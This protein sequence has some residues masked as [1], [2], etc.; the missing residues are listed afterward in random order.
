MTAPDESRDEPGFELKRFIPV[1]KSVSEQAQ[2]FLG[3]G[4]SIGDASGQQPDRNDID[5]WRAVIKA[6]DEMMVAFTEMV[7]AVPASTVDT[8]L[9]GDVQVFVLTPE[10]VPDDDPDQP[11]Y[12]DIHGGA[13]IMG[14]GDACRA[15]AT[16]VAAMTRMRTWSV[17]YRMAPDHPSPAALDDCI[18]VYRR[19]LEIKAPER[20]VVGGGSAGGNLA[21]AL[22]LRARD[23]GLPFPGALVLLTPEADLTALRRFHPAVPAHAHPGRDARSLPLQ[24]GAPAPED[25]NCRRRSGAPRVR[26]D[27]PRRILRRARRRRDRRR[28]PTVPRVTSRAMRSSS[29]VEIRC[30]R[31][32]APRASPERRNRRSCH[33]PRCRSLRSG[34]TPR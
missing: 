21:A 34:T 11:I 17:D 19:L 5:G 20:I 16:K 27:A 12:F 10:G 18:A 15:L 28:D 31:R 13:L 7:P 22:M 8:I 30:V 6:S 3:M 32:R 24:R 23:E 29:V 33:R 2:A 4:L 25:A 26:G 9:V 1:P 14:G